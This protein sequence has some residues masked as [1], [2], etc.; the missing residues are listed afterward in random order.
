MNPNDILIPAIVVFGLLVVGLVLTV[1]E[2]RDLHKKHGND[3]KD[4]AKKAE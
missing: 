1:L 3:D 4:S 2:F